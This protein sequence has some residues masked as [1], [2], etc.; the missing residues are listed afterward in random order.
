MENQEVNTIQISIDEVKSLN[1]IL[2]PVK[3]K[4]KLVVNIKTLSNF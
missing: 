3:S 4:E 1:V 2:Q